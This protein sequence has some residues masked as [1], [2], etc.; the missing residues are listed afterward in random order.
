MH[1]TPFWW[2]LKMPASG[3]IPTRRAGCSMRS[4]PPSPRVWA[5][6]CRSAD[7]SSRA[8]VAGCGPRA[9][10]ALAPRSSLS[11]Q[12]GTRRGR[13]A[14]PGRRLAAHLAEDGVMVK[15]RSLHHDPARVGT[16]QEEAREPAP[17]LLPRGL[18]PGVLSAVRAGDQDFAD[19]AA[20]QIVFAQ[21]LDLKVGDRSDERPVELSDSLR[22]LEHRLRR[23]EVP[24][25]V[26]VLNEGP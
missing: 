4:S 12:P 11:S 25:R 3:W 22:A 13:D 20:W 14:L 19:G 2:P 26:R 17:D 24:S 21:D 5:W 1:P 23:H 8:T 9:T 7:R 18:D 15:V 6:A 16:E 10:P